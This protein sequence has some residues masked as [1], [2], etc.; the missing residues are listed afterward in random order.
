MHFS[1]FTAGV[2][3]LGC[4]LG[5]PGDL[6]KYRCPGPITTYSDGTQWSGCV[7]G[8][9]IFFRAPLVILM[10]TQ[11]E[12]V[13]LR[14]MDIGDQCGSFFHNNSKNEKKKLL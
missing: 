10:C 8:T 12:E 11:G 4:T 6:R 14:T 3:N 13:M 2:L 9:G 1:L 7:L 5:S